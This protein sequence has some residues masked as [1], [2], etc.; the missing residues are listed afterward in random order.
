[1]VKFPLYGVHFW[2]P[3][4]HVEAPV[5]GSIILAGVLLK[6]GGYGIYRFTWALQPSLASFLSYLEVFR[7][8]GGLVGGLVCLSQYD[9][10]VLIA[11]SSVRHMSLRIR[12]VLRGCSGGI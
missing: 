1:M 12:G 11:Y 5:G 8:L 6:L 7:I 4:A 9:L 10:K 3:K 2:L